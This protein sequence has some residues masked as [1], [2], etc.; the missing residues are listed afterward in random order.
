ME[1]CLHWFW[2]DCV[3][4]FPLDVSPSCDY[5]IS[6][7]TYL[8]A[9]YTMTMACDRQP[10]T[11]WWSRQRAAYISSG[12]SKKKKKNEKAWHGSKW[13]TRSDYLYLEQI[14]LSLEGLYNYSN[15]E[16]EMCLIINHWICACILYIILRQLSS[17]GLWWSRS[18]SYY[19]TT[20]ATLMAFEPPV[21]GRR[22]I[23][24]NKSTNHSRSS[25]ASQ[26]H[27]GEQGTN[28]AHRM[29]WMMWPVRS[30]RIQM[31]R[32]RRSSTSCP[33]GVAKMRSFTCH[34]H[35]CICHGKQ[36]RFV[37]LIKY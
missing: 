2:R 15:R 33:S 3:L 34:R 6:T 22:N 37:R 12:W 27:V 25:G 31:A 4:I 13:G 24:V 7:L 17:K 23:H 20:H 9:A 10:L 1:R 5:G 16:R 30:T 18:G 26:E 35:N 29:H 14:A 21:H 11:R 19:R 28:K 8:V 32:L 36:Q